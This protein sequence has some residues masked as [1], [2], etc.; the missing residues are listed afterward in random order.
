MTKLA[1]ALLGAFRHSDFGFLS[2]FVIRHSTTYANQVHAPKQVV[3]VVG[4]LHEPYDALLANEQVTHFE[5]HGPNACGKKTKG[6]S[7]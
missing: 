6:G 2:S 7:P 3:K 5:V 4:A 1:I